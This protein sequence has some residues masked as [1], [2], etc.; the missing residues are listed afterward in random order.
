VKARIYTIK[1]KTRRT[2]VDDEYDLWTVLLRGG[3]GD[4]FDH[5][6]GDIIRDEFGT[7]TVYPGRYRFA[8]FN[9]AL[10]HFR[11]MYARRPRYD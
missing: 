2:E 8:T 3:D 11:S 9:K 1:T 5:N 7:F 10:G 6:V 4:L